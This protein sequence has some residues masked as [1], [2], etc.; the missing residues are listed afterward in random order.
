MNT[1]YTE[2]NAYWLTWGDANGL[3]MPAVDG[4]PGGTAT[5]PAYFHTT[6]YMEE[7]HNYQ[8]LRPSGPDDDRW[9]WNYIYPVGSPASAS[10][11]TTLQHLA[12]APL[13]ATVRGLFKGYAAYPQH[14]TQVYLNGHLIDDATWLPQTEY[15][16]EVSVPQSYL[17]EGT[18]TISVECLLDVEDGQN[19]VFVNRFEIDYYDTYVAEDDLL[20][21]DGDE[22]GT[23]EYHVGGFYTDTVEAFD[24]TTPTSPTRILSATV[25]P[26][27]TYTLTFE[28]TITAEHH[29]LALTPARR[30]SPLSIEEDNPSY[31]HSTANGADY[32]IVTHADF[33][34]DVLPLAAHRAAQGL[35]TM[36]VDVQDVYDEFSYGIFDPTA[37]HDF[38]AYAYADANWVPPAPAYVL[39]V[40]DGNYDFKDNFGRGEPNYVPPYLADVDPWIGEAPADNRYVCV[41]GDDILPDMDIGRLPVKTSAEASA[42][43][44][45]ILAYEQ[46]AL[47]DGWT[48]QVLFVADNHETGDFA[49]LSDAVADHYLPA[50]YAAQKV[51][52]KLT[53]LEPTEARA[54]IINA[55]NEG[56]LLVNYIGHASHQYWAGPVLPV[57]ERLLQISHI[58]A[59][60]NTERLP[61]MVPM[62]CLDGYFIHPS[63]PGLDYSS[64][65]ESIVRAPGKGAV[66]SWSPTGLGV[67]SGHDFLNKGLFEAIFFDDVVQLGPATRRAKL[68]LYS[69]TA[70]YR[71]LID[72]YALF[73]DPA[74]RLNVLHGGY[75]HLPL[76]LKNY[77]GQ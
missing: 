6:H 67:A 56:R 71:E 20:S 23:W 30:S 33:Y 55:I 47:D 75:L 38:L 73:G 9:Y 3:R 19:V 35:R 74:L 8:S 68:Y 7:D 72:T 15:A 13:S 64:L 69:N 22:A 42:V 5:V 29:Y 61:L 36:V 58:A 37:I 27:G 25:E 52:Y 48:Q 21:F 44:A 4:T 18:N 51:Y 60:T 46:H 1:R 40:G 57:D 43:V 53:H 11:T 17:I 77:P 32:V 49:A 34:T 62:T 65:G 12:T 66:A 16:F 39:L 10:Y 63:P 70:G 76:I 2:V 41:M 28:Q 31:L 24:V 14:H 54:A 26:G 45:K 59:L 50:P